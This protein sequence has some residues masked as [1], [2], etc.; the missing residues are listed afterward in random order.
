MIQARVLRNVRVF[1]DQAVLPTDSLVIDEGAITE[2]GSALPGPLGAVAVDAQ[3]GEHRPGTRPPA[4]TRQV[5]AP[6]CHVV[7]QYRNS[8]SQQADR[9]N[10]QERPQASAH[11]DEHALAQDRV[12]TRRVRVR[13]PWENPPR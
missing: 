10:R 6:A 4:V 7:E 13:R 8:R 2:M 5:T 9:S 12:A 11:A 1:D 3:R